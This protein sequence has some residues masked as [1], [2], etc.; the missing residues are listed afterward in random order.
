MRTKGSCRFE[1]Y[2]K[3]QF[4]N[5]FLAWQDVQQAFPTEDDARAHFI[6]GKECRV[7]QVTERGRVPL[8]QTQAAPTP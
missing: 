1:P 3:V 5:H 6:R 2:F 7:T 4:R 8:P